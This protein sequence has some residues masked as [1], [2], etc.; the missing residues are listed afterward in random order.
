MDVGRRYCR[1]HLFPIRSVW[2]GGGLKAHWFIWLGGACAIAA[3]GCLL[4]LKYRP[5][6]AAPIPATP[7]IPLPPYSETPYR[8][9]AAEADYIGTAACAECH[10]SRHASYLLTAHSRALAD[11][12]PGP[13]PRDG[14]FEHPLA[15]R[16]YRVYRAAPP[17]SLPAG[18]SRHAET[19]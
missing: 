9:T 15:G 7:S 8:N 16:S 1:T 17:G 12:D 6:N 11:V 3:I 13:E 4:W 14:P 19:V 2:V 18:P 10:R 5:S